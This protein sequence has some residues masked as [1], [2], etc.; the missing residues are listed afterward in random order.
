MFAFERNCMTMIFKVLQIV[1]TTNKYEL[2][3]SICVFSYISGIYVR[4]KNFFIAAG[5]PTIA[6]QED[7][8]VPGCKLT[9]FWM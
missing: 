3:I 5:F 1:I 9:T 7:A 4:Q 8:G 2:L 6:V